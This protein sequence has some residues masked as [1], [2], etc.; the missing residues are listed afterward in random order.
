MSQQSSR[1][2]RRRLAGTTGATT[3]ALLL[4]GCGAKKGA[5]SQPAQNQGSAG[6][7]HVG[8]QLNISTPF[9]RPS[10][11]PTV[12]SS[13]TET[14]KALIWTNDGLVNFKA[15]P[16]IGYNDL[17]VQ[18]MIA[19]RW[20]APDPQ[21]YVFHL[22]PGVKWANLPPLSGRLVTPADV[23]WTFEYLTRTGQFS[24]KNLPPSLKAALFAGLNQ[25]DTPDAATVTMRL[26]QPFAPFL[27][28]AAS[29]FGSIL[30][31]EIFDQDGD[32]SKRMVGTGPWQ[33][34]DSASQRGARTV[35]KKNDSYFLAGL[36]Y[37]DQI[38]QIILPDN[39]TV[40]AAFQSKQLDIV[41]YSGLTPDTVDRMKKVIP[42]LVVYDYIDPDPDAFYVN[43]TMPPLND[44]RIRQALALS[45]DRD[46]LLKTLAGGKGQ[47]ALAG[48]LPGLFTPEEIKQILKHDPAQAKQLVAAAGF[49][50]GVDLELIY[51]GAK[52]G[53]VSVSEIQLLQAQLKQGGTNLQLKSLDEASEG[54][55]KH[56]NDFQ[57][58]Y[59]TTPIQNDLDD[60]LY[61]L[62]HPTSGH[63]YT[64]IDDPELTPLLEAQRRETDPAKRRDLWRKAVQRINDQA[65]FLA[66]LYFQRTNLWWP[67]VHNYAP[68]WGTLANE[69]LAPSWVA[70]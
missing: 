61:S 50:D 35:F 67:A 38:N 32:F 57:L 4:A 22:R 34:D 6:K 41:D 54:T 70:K 20:E 28:Y 31:H 27:T 33:V 10:F 49:P 60:N 24:G 48:A 21:T 37:I 29:G 19:E 68:N 18:P 30:P 1:M 9:E 5:G 66:L 46:E 52:Y 56:A 55:R 40:N 69:P 11:D 13:V 25:I 36:P 64:K 58:D 2:S 23:K 59:T 16:G 17:I 44:L 53:Q 15:G 14:G 8:G 3:A 65:W 12:G 43:S 62:Y 45:I 51:P 7:P 63:N 47:W 26:A 42:G 39:S